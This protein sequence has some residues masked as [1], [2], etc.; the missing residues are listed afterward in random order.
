MTIGQITGWIRP[1]VFAK[2]YNT[3]LQNALNGGSPMQMFSFAPIVD[4]VNEKYGLM[5]K[6]N[7]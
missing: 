7:L 1:F 2:K 3:T 4:P 5:A 6:L